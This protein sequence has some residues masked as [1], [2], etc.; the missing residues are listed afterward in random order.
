MKLVCIFFIVSSFVVNSYSQLVVHGG[1]SPTTNGTNQKTELTK[2]DQ[3]SIRCHYQFVQKDKTGQLQTDTMTLDIGAQMSEYYDMTRQKQDSLYSA[4][5][6]KIDPSTISSVSVLKGKSALEYEKRGGNTY[7]S[8]RPKESARLLKN[9]QTGEIIIIDYLS[10]VPDKY[11]FTETIPPQAWQIAADTATILGYHCQKATATFRGRNYEAWFSP[12]IPVNEGPWKFFGLPGLILKVSDTDEI[13]S[14][15]CVGMENLILPRDI[16]MSQEKYIN[17]SRDE[18]AKIKRQ[19][20]GET[21]ISN[22]SGAI[23]I[24]QIDAKDDYHSLELE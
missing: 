15:V 5:F 4:Y 8:G 24:A 12:E 20:G 10:T 2:L 17:C 6:S 7:T 13:F 21:R 1:Q 19:Q 9:R 18:L 16:T 23:V 3:A 14:F 22:N 11:R